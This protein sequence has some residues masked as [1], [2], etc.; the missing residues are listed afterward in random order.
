MLRKIIMLWK[1]PDPCKECLVKVICRD[2]CDK[3]VQWECKTRDF[4][5][6]YKIIAGMILLIVSAFAY[7]VAL[8]ALKYDLL[9]YEEATAFNL[10]PD[11]EEPDEYYY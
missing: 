10:F 8:I 6:A 11:W 1:D 9:T 5:A 7:G 4:F 2:Q 3:K